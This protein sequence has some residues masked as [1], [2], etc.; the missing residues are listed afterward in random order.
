[1]LGLIQGFEAA[2]IH[3]KWPI[4]S[5]MY[6][7]S[8]DRVQCILFNE[9]YTCVWSIQTC[10]D[11]IPDDFVSNQITLVI[12]KMSLKSQISANFLWVSSFRD[13]HLDCAPFNRLRG[14]F[15]YKKVKWKKQKWIYKL[16]LW[17]SFI[18]TS[19]SDGGLSRGLMSLLGRMPSY[20]RKRIEPR[21]YGRAELQMGKEDKVK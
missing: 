4:S 14:F 13:I 5:F 19:V 9:L 15:F 17:S 2:Q 8:A 11:P 21:S 18:W 3:V 12:Q 1:M 10:S 7:N 6:L 20:Q 16:R